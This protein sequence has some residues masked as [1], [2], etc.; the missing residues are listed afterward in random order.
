MLSKDV[1]SGLNILGIVL[2]RPNEEL[3]RNL[4][5]SKLTLIN[6]L[7]RCE[8][9]RH[10]CSVF[11]F[12]RKLAVLCLMCSDGSFRL[13]LGLERCLENCFL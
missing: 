7:L 4:E 1:L 10:C 13:G 6:I 9:T 5:T 8:Q 11:H 3:Q 12:S 2:S